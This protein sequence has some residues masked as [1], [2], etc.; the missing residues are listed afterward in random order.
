MA[1]LAGR[2]FRNIGWALALDCLR[3]GVDGSLPHPDTIAPALVAAVL[4]AVLGIAIALT[5]LPAPPAASLLPASDAT[6]A[7]LGTGWEKPTLATFE[8]TAAAVRMV[9][10]Q[11]EPAVSI[12]TAVVASV[13]VATAHGRW[14]SRRSRR[15]E[16]SPSRRHHCW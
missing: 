3:T 15:R 9:T 7:G 16:A 13:T 12:L 11:A 5:G 14:Y 10:A 8:Q 2:L 6:V 4:L 1:G